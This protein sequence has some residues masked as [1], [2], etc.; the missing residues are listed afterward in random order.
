MPFPNLFLLKNPTVPPSCA[1]LCP[2]V[3]PSCLGSCA[4]GISLFDQI[5]QVLEQEAATWTTPCS[6]PRS[7]KS[8]ALPPSP[9]SSKDDCPELEVD[10]CPELEVVHFISDSIHR[11]FLQV[12]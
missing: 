2:H 11:G 10:D 8:Y 12:D 4:L 5:R 6:S 1:N 9:D 3:P 7:S